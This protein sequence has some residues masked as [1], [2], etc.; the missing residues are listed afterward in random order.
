MFFMMRILFRLL[1]VRGMFFVFCFLFFVFC[2]L[3]VVLVLFGFGFVGFCFVVF[4]FVLFFVF[5]WLVWLG[6]R[7]Y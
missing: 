7:Q 5:G 4:F 3:F 1:S 2:F 6:E